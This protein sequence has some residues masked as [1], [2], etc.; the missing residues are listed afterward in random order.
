M[1]RGRSLEGSWIWAGVLAT[2]RHPPL[3]SADTFS[4]GVVRRER[5]QRGQ[6]ERVSDAGM[7]EN[8]QRTVFG[9]DSFG[10]MF[11]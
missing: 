4:V 10:P 3:R 9:F 1:A 2:Q 11:Y 6:W 8:V 7:W 5:K